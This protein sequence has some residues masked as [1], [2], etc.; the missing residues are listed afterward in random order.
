[1]AISILVTTA[2]TIFLR[3]DSVI[4][5]LKPLPDYLHVCRRSNPDIAN[6]IMES[7]YFLRTKLAAGIP[8]LGV[9]PMDPMV[10]NTLM[11]SNGHGI[12]IETT[13]LLVT[14]TSNFTLSYL[15]ANIDRQKYE[16]QVRFPHMH[17]LGNYSIDGRIVRM[18]IKGHGD[19]DLDIYGVKCNVSLLG[20]VVDIDGSNYIRFNNISLRIMVDKG[21]IELRNLFGGDKNLGDV[22]NSAINSNFIMFFMELRPIIQKVLEEFVLDTVEKLTRHFT[23]EQLFPD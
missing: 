16:F 3:P 23:Y 13:N 7:A 6:C 17:V 12:K 22:L 10:I 11:P 2:V 4:S 5:E 14:G 20:N 21:K 19:F 1:M 18:A 15:K 8:E 9:A